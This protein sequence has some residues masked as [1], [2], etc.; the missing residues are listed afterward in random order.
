MVRDWMSQTVITVNAEGSMQDA[1][2]LLKT[3]GIKMLPV[4]DHGKLVGIITDRDI[5]RTSA[6]DASSLE[7][8]ELIYLLSKI[9]IKEVM[10]PNPVT[11]A[12]D[13]TIEETAQ[14]LLANKISGVPVMAPD[15]TIAGIISQS[16]LFRIIASLTGMA[17]TGIQIA[18]QAP[19]HPGIIS[20]V[21]NIIRENQGRI[22][23][24]LSSHAHAPDGFRRIYIRTY[25]IDRD[26]L[27]A[28]KTALQEKATMLYLVDHRN[29][30]RE[31]Y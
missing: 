17:K 23:S 19:D 4:L 26:K 28:I 2:H 18:L 15:G 7:I 10:T 1:V 13:A 12:S 8:H 21:F 30:T 16:D 24:V 27:T 20:E 31:I 5:K 11:V 3:H 6:S 29:N 14:V 22:M 9:K 25:D